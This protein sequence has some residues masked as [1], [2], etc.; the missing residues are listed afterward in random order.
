[1][2]KIYSAIALL[3]FVLCHSQ[4]TFEKGYF[5][6]NTGTRTECF[7]KNLDW[8]NNP[9]D[10]VYK[11]QME[12]ADLKA[13]NIANV[14]EFGIDDVSKY[15]RF[16]VKIERSQSALATL[17][18]SKTPLFKMETL[19]LRF[20]VN[21]DANLYVYSDENLTK[22]FYDTPQTPIEQLVRIKYIQSETEINSYNESVR[23]NNQFRQQLFNNVRCD[24]INE[25]GIENIRYDKNDLINHFTT[26][27]SCG[28]N[29]VVNFD[30]KVKRKSYALR[31]TPGVYMASLSINDPATFYNVGTD[32][33]KTIFKIG[34]EGEYILPFN[35]NMWSLFIN[36]T[37]QQFDVKESYVKK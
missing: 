17:G 27:N 7:I 20:L 8:R 12:S 25:K 14:A 26:Y 10:F 21:G 35:K 13:G 33:N 31:I 5:I 32:V 16:T 29:A 23:E 15:K 18:K 36:P 19:F 37:Y 24:K 1:M 2:K 3:S 6:D 34:F 22:Y 4:I 30:E 11:D 9:A 28:A